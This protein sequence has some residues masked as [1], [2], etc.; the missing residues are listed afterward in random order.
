M[1]VLAPQTLLP[2]P[3]GYMGI[4]LLLDQDDTALFLAGIPEQRL[5]AFDPGAPEDMP[6]YAASRDVD[7]DHLIGT[8]HGNREVNIEVRLYAD[9]DEDLQ[10]LV[11]SLDAK[12]D[13][14]RREGGVLVCTLP[15]GE[16]YL[17]PVLAGAP[18]MRWDKRWVNRPCTTYSLRLTCGPYWLDAEREITLDVQRTSPCVIATTDEPVPGSVPAL[19]RLVVENDSAADQAFVMWAQ[20]SR[21]YDPAATAALFYEAE[22]LVMLG[23]SVAQPGP[24]LGSSDGYVNRPGVPLLS[25]WQAIVST[26]PLTHTGTYRVFLRAGAGTVQPIDIAL[27]WGT[28]DFRSHTRN[29]SQN[30]GFQ[31]IGSWALLDLGLV[32]IQPGDDQWE[33][34]I[35]ARSTHYDNAY[36]TLDCLYLMP[37]DEGYGEASGQKQA[38][39]ATEFVAHDDF[40]AYGAGNLAGQT[41]PVGGDWVGVGDSTDYQTSGAGLAFRNAVSDTS[42]RVQTADDTDIAGALIRA[43]VAVGLGSNVSYA[44]SGLAARVIDANNFVAGYVYRQATSGAISLAIVAWLSGVPR[45]IDIDQALGYSIPWP[46]PVTADMTL[47]VTSD[48]TVEAEAVLSTGRILSA[49]GAAPELADGAA[50][51]SG[52]VGLFDYAPDSGSRSSTWDDFFAHAIPSDPAVFGNR[53]LEIRS[54]RV[55][56]DDAVGATI[57]RVSRYAGDLLTIPASGSQSR[58]LRLIAKG[59]R[60]HPETNGATDNHL[61]ELNVRLLVTPRWLTLPGST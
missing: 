42:P 56:R 60:M 39:T 51:E 28:G 32:Q 49:A 40:E 3:L 46:V 10:N 27:E 57:T 41:L 24:T 19:G 36:V 50:L 9:T 54:D 30:I 22:D 1:P 37:V 35:I 13:K 33:G 5:T 14:L 38:P 52:Q 15:S 43:R 26:G 6:L 11:A 23:G 48:G 4:T 20:Q 2:F 53:A 17:L 55:V 21:H 58:P 44:S 31:P 45:F 12:V 61:D 18:H 16:P 25:E 34:R 59:T 47:Q 8:R 29:P 7:G